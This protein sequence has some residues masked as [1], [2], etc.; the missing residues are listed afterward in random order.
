MAKSRIKLSVEILSADPVMKKLVDSHDPPR[1]GKNPIFF[2]LVR[3]VI[4][5]QLSEAAA[6]TIFKRLSA[7]AAITPEA[8]SSLD[9][10]TFRTCGIS[11]PKARYIIG[12]ADAALS[13]QLENFDNLSDEDAIKALVKLK[14][15]GQWTAEM[16]L[17]FSL[18]RENVWPCDDAGLLRVA[19]R[20]YGI[21]DVAGF[22]D[23]GERFRPYR[24]HVAWYL[25]ASLDTPS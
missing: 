5:Q 22:I 9:V 20:L 24:T 8:L 19:K 25:W 21:Q 12:I 15:V 7:I 10:D 2:S 3:A 17:I 18:G 16:I 14:G 6:S 1:I 13:G 4:S 23:L 11:T